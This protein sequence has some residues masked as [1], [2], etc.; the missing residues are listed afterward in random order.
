VNI[1]AATVKN[2]GGFIF[3]KRLFMQMRA[4]TYF[5]SAEILAR[6]CTN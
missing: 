2:G 6:L 3:A 1:R 5:G 4:I